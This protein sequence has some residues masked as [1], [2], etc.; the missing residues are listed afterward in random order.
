LERRQYPVPHS[1]A[2]RGCGPL[3]GGGLAKDNPVIEDAWIGAG[4]Q[5][6]N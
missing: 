5:D 2:E 6:P 1:E 3:Q 4:G